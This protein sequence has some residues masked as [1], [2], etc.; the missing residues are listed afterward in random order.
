M[1]RII[2]GKAY[3]RLCPEIYRNM[4]GRHQLNTCEF[5][6]HIPLDQLVLVF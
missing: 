2:S 1:W 6:E 3:S 5:T 4:T